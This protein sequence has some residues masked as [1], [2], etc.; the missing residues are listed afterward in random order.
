MSIESTVTRM[1]DV[2]EIPGVPQ[3]WSW[4]IAGGWFRFWLA[5]G[6]DGRHAFQMTSRDS[7]D[8][9]LAAAVLEFSRANAA[10]LLSAAPLAVV[11]GFSFPGY[12]FDCVSALIPT[13][14]QLHQGEHPELTESVFAVFPA[15]RCEFSGDESEDEA[16]VRYDKVLDT[17][18]LSRGPVPFLRMSYDIPAKGMGSV[19]G[20][21]GLA[22]PET[23]MLAVSELSEAGRG[24]VECENFR[25][26]VRRIEWDGG[27]VFLVNGEERR[28][29]S[30]AE[31]TGWIEGFLHR[32]E[33]D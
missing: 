19:G 33:G 32:G 11:E 16:G 26:Q 10:A 4:S 21:R 5:L 31:L 1:P 24:F 12:G 2:G 15:W 28:A 6:S 30:P 29:V 25:G 20:R 9:K 22:V 13:V 27:D 8:E 18:D 14:A 3:A 23:L 7:H 17:P